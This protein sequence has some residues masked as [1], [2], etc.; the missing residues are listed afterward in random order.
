M[1]ISKLT[2][3]IDISGKDHIKKQLSSNSEEDGERKNLEL[4]IRMPMIVSTSGN[5]PDNFEETYVEQ[6]CDPCIKSKYT[7][8]VKYKSMTPITHKLQEIHTDL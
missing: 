6:L 1:K 5:Y 7:K 8:I 2:D 3:R 4:F